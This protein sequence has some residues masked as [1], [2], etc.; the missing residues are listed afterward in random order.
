[1]IWHSRLEYA[2]AK[3]FFCKHLGV[4]VGRGFE[5]DPEKWKIGLEQ[6][7]ELLT[8]WYEWE[9]V[10]RGPE[11][12][13]YRV[14]VFV[15]QIV[16]RGDTVPHH[17]CSRSCP[18]H[19]RFDLEYMQGMAAWKSTGAQYVGIS[20]ESDR[21][22]FQCELPDGGMDIQDE[23]V[24]WHFANG[25]ECYS[26]REIHAMS[27][28]HFK[29]HEEDDEPYLRIGR[30]MGWDLLGICENE[31]HLAEYDLF[32]CLC[33]CSCAPSFPCFPLCV[34]LP[35]AMYISVYGI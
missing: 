8:V 19:L 7:K 33:V 35:A 20:Y 34:S 16:H 26:L 17:P 10:T 6:G 3:H 23:Q 22:V 24:Y 1:M 2:A 31:V 28:I 30:R 13:P 9:H 27:E 11:N 4:Q 18:L 21:P 32:N 12:E 15:N 25:V 5:P 14:G 29:L